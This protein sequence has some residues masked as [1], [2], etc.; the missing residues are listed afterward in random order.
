M[1][2]FALPAGALLLLG[3]GLANRQSDDTIVVISGN[4]LGH[5]TPCGC[6]QPMSGG[7][8]VMAAYI[9]NL[10]KEANVYWLDA[11]SV[12]SKPGQQQ[13]YKAEAYAELLKD[14]GVDVATATQNDRLLGAG[15]LASMSSLIGKK[16]LGDPTGAEEFVESSQT[17]GDLT[18]STNSE[19]EASILVSDGSNDHTHSQLTVFPSDGK[20]IVEDNR[21]SPGSHLRGVVLARFRKGQLQ[22][23]SVYNFP[24]TAKNDAGADAVYAYYQE[25]V[26]KTGLINQV[27]LAD[28]ADNIGSFNCK[29]CHTKVYKQHTK[30]KHYHAYETLK[31]VKSDADPECVI[32][33]V[34]GLDAK[35][36]FRYQK[37]PGMEQVGCESCHGGGRQHAKFPKSVRMPKV[38]EKSCVPCHTPQN[39]GGFNFTKYWAK[40][41]H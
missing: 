29:S 41:R 15:V 3:A 27:L 40:I 30:T 13:Q 33:H 19:L 5:I 25:R 2:K 37:T 20:P 14:V 8:S 23:V 17:M 4:A 21:V 26:R 24:P 35:H 1:K 7:L 28:N 16:L 18:V 38:G 6:T 36:G 22:S 9:R 34:T 11:G 12:V 39:S 10:K 31:T 32:C